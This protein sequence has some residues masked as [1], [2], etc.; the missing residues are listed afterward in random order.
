MATANNNGKGINN[1]Q[2]KSIR[3]MQI[4]LQHSRVATDNLMNLI[5]QNRTDVVFI[6]EPYILQ[7]KTAGITRTHM[8]YISNEDKSKA[9]IIVANDNI[10]AVLKQLCD[11]DNAVLEMRYNSTRIF[12]VSMYFDIT[13]EIYRKTAKID[14]IL[15]YSK[16]SGILIVM[17]SNSRSTLWYDNQ[18]NPRGKT[19]EEYLISK[20]LN[21]MNEESELTTFQSRRGSSDIDLMIVNNRLL[22][23]FND[24]EISG[25]ESCS[26]HDIIEFKLEHETNHEMQHNHNGIKYIVKEQ[27]CN[28]FDK[29][30]KELVAK[31]FR[32]VNPQDSTS[33]DSDLAAYIKETDDIERAVG[34]LQEAITSSCHKSFKTRE[35]A[36]KTIRYKSVPWWTVELTIKRKRL[37]ALRRR[38][39]RTKNNAALREYRKNTYYEEKTKYQTIKRE[40]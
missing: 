35:T 30:L 36:Q 13:E 37:N 25:D 11:R 8:T 12:A 19:L 3:C 5:Q 18:T 21:I 23:N 28:R 7:N 9:A 10:D 20:D 1:N 17:D 39:Q 31:K 32:M 26:D 34:K 24:W 29:N 2:L 40:N 33:L 15:Q 22:K 27:D 4:N 14:E 38:Y 6:Q 16:C